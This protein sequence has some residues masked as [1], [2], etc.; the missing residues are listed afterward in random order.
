MDSRKFETYFFILLLLIV[1]VLGLRIVFPYLGTLILA[2][3]LALVC[4]PVYRALARVFGGH[5]AWSAAISVT[6]VCIIILIPLSYFGLILVEEAQS[7]LLAGGSGSGLSGMAGDR[8]FENVKSI[9][10]AGAVSMLEEQQLNFGQYLSMGVSWITSNIGVIFSGIADFVLDLVIGIM[11]FYYFLKD[12]DR[13]R[14]AILRGSPLGEENTLRIMDRLIQTIGSVVNGTVIVA[15]VQGIL[16]GIGFAFCGLPSP[17]L[18]GFATVIAALVPTF[19]TAITTVPAVGYLLLT[20]NTFGALGA[21]IWGFLVVAQID[22]FIRSKLI[23]KGG[24]A[25]H[26]F[27]ILLSVFGGLSLFGPIGFLIGPLALSFLFALFEIF[28]AIIGAAK[29]RKS[30]AS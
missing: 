23:E 20:G 13:L 18:W 11:A 30:A 22:T 25:L 28:P 14:R 4:Q 17:A 24:V 9:L 6:L 15:L 12:G 29:T 8:F 2:G 19:G 5:R 7:L 3:T 27:L 21:A 26:P 1:F 10:P 16:A